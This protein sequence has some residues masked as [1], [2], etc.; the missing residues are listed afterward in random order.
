MQAAVKGVCIMVLC[1]AMTAANAFTSHDLRSFGYEVRDFVADFAFINF[2]VFSKETLLVGAVAAPLWAG[3]YQIDD[4]IHRC[5]YDDSCHR[6]EIECRA[7]K[8]LFIEDAGIAVPLLAVSGYAWASRDY[9]TR[10]LGRNLF[11][12][13][14]A[15]AIAKDAIKDSFEGTICQ[16]PYSGWFPKKCAYGG[17]PS[18]HAATLTYATILC[19]LRKG[20]AWAL[21]VGMYTGVV[22]ASLLVNNYHYASQIVAGAG[23]GAIFAV[24]AHKVIDFRL[25]DRLHINAG[26][27]P[28]GVPGVSFSYSF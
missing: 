14:I 11:A 8:M 22:I 3:T 4:P 13:I 23:L 24:A 6:N 25:D 16:R 21:P 10:L 27:T 7:S 18:G 17:F 9:E 20:P 19:A 15:V 28:N 12:G 5:F 1:G 26:I 2:N